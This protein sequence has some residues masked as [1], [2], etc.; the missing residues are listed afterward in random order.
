MSAGLHLPKRVG[1]REI[2]VMALATSSGFTFAPIFATALVPAGPMLA[3]L[4]LGA[5]V[6]AV[7]A[8][9]ALAVARL[10]RRHVA[11]N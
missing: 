7:G 6:S 10:L 9:I 4:K 5:L 8:L 11:V 1:W 2:V 3:Q